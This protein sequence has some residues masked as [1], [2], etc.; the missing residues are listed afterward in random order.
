MAQIA[1]KYARIN[2]AGQL[3]LQWYRM[4][5]LDQEV[6]DLQE[7]TNVVKMNTLKSGSL[8]ETDD[9]TITG[10]RVTEENKGGT[11]DADVVYQYG[12]DGYVLEITGNQLIQEGKGSR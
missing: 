7:N 1:C 5:L 12:E 8:I 9:V 11:S 10:I 6:S 3:T 2:N 4:E